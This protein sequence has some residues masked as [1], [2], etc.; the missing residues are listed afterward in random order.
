MQF[1]L[2]ALPA[3]DRQTA[4]RATTLHL[5]IAIALC[6]MAAGCGMLVWFKAILPATPRAVGPTRVFS[7][8]CLLCGSGI[9][10]LTIF[11]RSWIMKGRR[12]FLLRTM[13]VAL[14]AVLTI[15]F[16]S[17]GHTKAAIIFSGVTLAILL[18]AIYEGR[19]RPQEHTIV[20]NDNGVKVPKSGLSKTYRWQE[21]ESLLLRHGILSIEL[22]GNILVQ[23]EL[24]KDD[25]DAGLLEAFAASRIAAFAKERAANALW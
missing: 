14:M 25:V 23:R 19:P 1:E 24:G 17:A 16:A 4:R 5:M 18:V 12:S 2:L 8:I 11:R 3:N 6:A 9:L 22:S 10:A 20:V 13:E 15:V 7:I 21:I